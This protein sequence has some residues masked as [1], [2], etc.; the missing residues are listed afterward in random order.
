MNNYIKKRGVNSTALLLLWIICSPVNAVSA[1]PIEPV[2]PTLP[3]EW[4]WNSEMTISMKEYLVMLSLKAGYEYVPLEREVS[5][6]Q[7]NIPLSIIRQEGSLRDHLLDITIETGH[8]VD[9]YIQKKTVRLRCN[10]TINQPRN[11]S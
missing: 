3:E 2:N 5:C 7:E 1:I 10:E 9:I 11:R 6:E 4:E 8:R